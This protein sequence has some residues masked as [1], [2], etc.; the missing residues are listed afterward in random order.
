MRQPIG[1]KSRLQHYGWERVTFSGINTVSS[2]YVPPACTDDAYGAWACRDERDLYDSWWSR[3]KMRS[4]LLQLSRADRYTVLCSPLN[5]STLRI[6]ADRDVSV[7]RYITDGRFT[8]E[9]SIAAFHYSRC[10]RGQPVWT[11][12]SVRRCPKTRR[13]CGW[14]NISRWFLKHCYA[15]IKI[16]FN[17]W[18]IDF[19]G[20][21]IFCD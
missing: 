17:A 7:H 3:R 14:S 20:S 8:L 6:P 5:W 16:F 21:T 2:R 19:V 9:F 13:V 10:F 4:S 12:S 15:N 18:K 1:N 11:G